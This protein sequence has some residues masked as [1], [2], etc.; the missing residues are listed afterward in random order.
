MAT[1]ANFALVVNGVPTI[2][3]DVLRYLREHPDAD[4]SSISRVVV[5]GSATPRS[6][7]QE[8]RD[9]YDIPRPIMHDSVGGHTV[10]ARWRDQR[11]IAELDGWMFHNTE[12][13]YENDRQRDADNLEAQHATIRITRRRMKREPAKVARQLKSI[14]ATRGAA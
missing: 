4:V 9:E 1:T 10:D 3:I 8:L 13:D 14:L 12:F 5:G 6:L 11:L 2:C 7:M